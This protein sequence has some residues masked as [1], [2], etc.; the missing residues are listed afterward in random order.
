MP[1]ESLPDVVERVRDVLVW[2]FLLLDVEGR[3]SGVLRR[4]DLREVL[5]SRT[6]RG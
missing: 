4:E 6:R 5:N 3:P 1:D 2:Q